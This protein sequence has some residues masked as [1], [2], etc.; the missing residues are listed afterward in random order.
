MPLARM[1]ITHTQ[2]LIAHLVGTKFVGAA[3]YDALTIPVVRE[4]LRVHP[5]GTLTII[6]K[7]RN[8]YEQSQAGHIQ[9]SNSHYH[10]HRYWLL[11]ISCQ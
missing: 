2:P 7:L 3:Q 8:K 11:H 4:F 10:Y 1:G 5:V 9:K 6:L